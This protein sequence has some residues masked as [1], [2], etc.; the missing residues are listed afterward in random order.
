MSHYL[1]IENRELGQMLE[2]M[3]RFSLMLDIHK[4]LSGLDAKELE[5]ACDRLVGK[6]TITSRRES[7][8]LPPI[9]H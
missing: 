8:P 1:V 3:G 4:S 9:K 6:L 5:I 2:K 7:G